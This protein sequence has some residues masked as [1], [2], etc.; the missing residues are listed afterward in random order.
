MSKKSYVIMRAYPANYVENLHPDH[1]W[2]LKP[3]EEST[4]CLIQYHPS[5]QLTTPFSVVGVRD[6][7]IHFIEHCE[8]LV[9]AMAMLKI[10]ITAF[11]RIDT[12][13]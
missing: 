13:L 4:Y 8:D 12:V 10:S 6:N 9:E 1:F 7:N 5:K 11:K 3:G 2:P